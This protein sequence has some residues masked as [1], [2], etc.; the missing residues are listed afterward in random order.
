MATTTSVQPDQIVVLRDVRWE[1]FEQFLAETPQRRVP[2]IA[3]NGSDL[4]LMTPS[5]THE[6][7]LFV[8]IYILGVLAD[9]FDL[10]AMGYGAATWIRP[11]L[12]VGIEA[13][14]CFYLHKEAAVRALHTIDLTIHPPPDLAIEVDIN[15]ELRQRMNIYAAIGVPEVW[16]FHDHSLTGWVLK[17]TVDGTKAY[18]EMKESPM[19]PEIPLTE[20]AKFVDQRTRKGIN[21]LLDEVRSWVQSK[22]TK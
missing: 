9:E 1:F 14:A 15:R 18:V 3:F 10:D 7:I 2:R 19:F 8:L 11:D 6:R 17:E 4:E 22:R 20:V 12:Q 5:Q 13:D 16:R 21:E